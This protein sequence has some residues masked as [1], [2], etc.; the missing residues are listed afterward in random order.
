MAI[1]RADLEYA[2]HRV[3]RRADNRVIDGKVN[4]ARRRALLAVVDE[5]IPNRKVQLIKPVYCLRFAGQYLDVETGLNYNYFRDY[6]SA[7]GRY[8]ESDPIGI[9]GGGYSTYVYADGNP[10]YETDPLGLAPP[11]RTDP[12][13]GIA[14]PPTWPTDTQPSHDAALGLENWLNN[15]ANG[16]ATLCR[17]ALDEC[18]RQYDEGVG[19][20]ERWRGRG[21]KGDRDRWYRACKVR[22]A[23]RRGLCQKK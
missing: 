4:R 18:Y 10:L 13:P 7:T 9:S 5:R 22:A 21:P 12:W 17:D 23:D 20:C 2:F 3:D 6:D 8:V 19:R 16:V 14:V 15:V 1:E 11:G